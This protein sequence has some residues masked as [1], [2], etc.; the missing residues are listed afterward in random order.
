MRRVAE[1]DI[2]EEL[3]L[4]LPLYSGVCIQRHVASCWSFPALT[5]LAESTDITGGVCTGLRPPEPVPAS[6]IMLEAARASI[7]LE[8]CLAISFLSGQH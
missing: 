1:I 5:P 2:L 6:F 3:G 7:C 4:L 8:I